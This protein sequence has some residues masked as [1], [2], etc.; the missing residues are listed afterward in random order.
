MPMTYAQA[1]SVALRRRREL[2]DA[3]NSGDTISKIN[4]ARGRYIASLQSV[5]RAAD[6]EGVPHTSY[7]YVLNTQLR[8]HASNLQRAIDN[9]KNNNYSMIKEMGLGMRKLV[10]S[11]RMYQNANSPTDKRAAGSRVV[12]SVAENVKNVVK[13]PVV[14]ATKILSSS[15]AASVML[16]PIALGMGILNAAWNAI[17]PSPSPYEDKVMQHSPALKN[18]MTKIHKT[19]QKI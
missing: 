4:Y 5:I 19:V 15:L 10:N 14:V 12:K 6:R 7:S 17:D 13:A 18:F 9:N 8:I 2:I 16:A 11:V 3:I 1:E